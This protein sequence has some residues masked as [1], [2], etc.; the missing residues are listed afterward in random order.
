MKKLFSIILATIF[1]ISWFS[2]N[3]EE[4]ILKTLENENLIQKK[5]TDMATSTTGGFL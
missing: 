3:S 1:S 5:D 4:S 2:K